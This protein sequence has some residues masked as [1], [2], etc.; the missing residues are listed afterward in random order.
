M[1]SSTPSNNGGEPDE[2]ND[3]KEVVN[4]SCTEVCGTGEIG[5][6]CSKICITKVYPK[7]QSDKAIKAY[8]SPDDQSNWSLAKSSFFQMFDMTECEQHSYFLRTCSGTMEK[9]ARMA[10]EFVVE[11]LNGKV[12][13]PLQPLIEC[14]EILDNRSE[15]PTPDAA[16]S[17]PHLIKVAE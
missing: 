13:I 16:R 4:S 15:I 11:S 5:R 2:S 9:T 1:A 17:H 10:E 8:F 6:S 12:T 3:I 7:G 14:N